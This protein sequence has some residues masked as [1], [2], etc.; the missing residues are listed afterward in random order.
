M[1]FARIAVNVASLSGTFDYHLP[2]DLEGK[3]VPGVLVTV[4]FGRQTVQGVVLELVS[5]PMVSETKPVI[6]ILDPLPVLTPV[7]VAL[8]RW[9]AGYFLDSLAAGIDLMLPP[10][11]GQRADTQYELSGRDQVPLTGGLSPVQKR[12]VELLSGRGPLRGRARGLRE[13]NVGVLVVG[14]PLLE[15][16]GGPLRRVRVP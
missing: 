8:V 14:E 15:G 16:F 3:I 2:P 6:G 9:M 11:L 1:V 5:Q 10:G 4:P 12:V 7:Q 13:V